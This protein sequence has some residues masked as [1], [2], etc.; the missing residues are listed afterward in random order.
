MTVKR[1]E[2]LGEILDGHPSYFLNDKE[3]EPVSFDQQITNEYLKTLVETNIKLTQ[4]GL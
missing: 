1:M 3:D 4:N 2:Q